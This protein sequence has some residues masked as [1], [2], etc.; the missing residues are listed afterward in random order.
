MHWLTN[1]SDRFVNYLQTNCEP[2]AKDFLYLQTTCKGFWATCKG[3]CFTSKPLDKNIHRDCKTN[4]TNFQSVFQSM[5]QICPRTR[6]K[7]SKAPRWKIW[8]LNLK[9]FYRWINIWKPAS[10][11]TGL[12]LWLKFMFWTKN[13]QKSMISKNTFFAR[14]KVWNWEKFTIANKIACRYHLKHAYFQIFK[15][16]NKRKIV[17]P[18]KKARSLIIMRFETGT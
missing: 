7:A 10:K 13:V 4:Q 2:L 6:H 3:I 14:K 12:K 8:V 17:G 11:D 15:P 5:S 9:D 18:K 1:I 16:I